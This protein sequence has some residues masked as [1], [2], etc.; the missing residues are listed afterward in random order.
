MRIEDREDKV[1]K[2]SVNYMS[3]GGVTPRRLDSF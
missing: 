3:L 2:K 1:F